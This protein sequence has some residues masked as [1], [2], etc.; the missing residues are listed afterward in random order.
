MSNFTTEVRYICENYAGYD[1]SQDYDKVDDIISE[2]RTKIFSNFPIFDEAYRS[3]IQSKILKHYYTREIGFETVGLW[4]LKLNTKLE[5]I[6]PYYNKLYES[7]L[8]K[9]DPLHDTDITTSSSRIGSGNNERNDNENKNSK[10]NEIL[11][12]VQTDIYDL[13]TTDNGTN[14]NMNRYSDTPQGG[15]DELQLKENAY[16]TNA[17]IDN[18]S[19]QNTNKKEGTLSR[20]NSG[21]NSNEKTDVNSLTSTGNYNNTEQYIESIKGKRSGFTYAGLLKEFRQTFLNIDLM[22]IDELKDLFM[23]IYE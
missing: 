11:G 20:S 8:L 6:M 10:N 1:D 19:N 2:A 14:S 15:V 13:T 4:K 5:E 12:T 18:G 3:V 9:F 7:A 17:T 23:Q 22:I 16:L 21:S